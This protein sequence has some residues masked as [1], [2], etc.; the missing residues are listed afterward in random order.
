VYPQGAQS[1]YRVDYLESP[2]R[3]RS[4]ALV[5]AVVLVALAIVGA[6]AGLVARGGKSASP[7][8]TNPAAAVSSSA[9]AP[10]PRQ[11]SPSQGPSVG[12]AQPPTSGPSP[13][14]GRGPLDSYLLPPDLIGSG[15]VMALI[16]GGRSVTDQA[17]LDFCNVDYAS[18]KLRDARVQVQYA[19]DGRAASN[20]FVRYR[21]GGAELAFAEIQ[22]AIAS[23]ASSYRQSGA[24]ISDIHRL[25]GLTGLAKNNAAVSF[26]STYT[27]IGGVVHQATTVI[28]QFDGDYFSGVYVYGADAA[29][30]QGAAGKLG[31]ASAR[32][33]A[34]AASGEPGTGGGP[35]TD[36]GENAPGVQT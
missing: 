2:A 27:G 14:Q 8:P 25:T 1:P 30:V 19:A 11:T 12:G 31:I 22:K 35:M 15:A 10:E 3:R 4:P 28:Y 26:T 7:P 16:P 33:L 29:S 21:P 18:E 34:E 20:E 23:C 9:G 32:L 17:T 6:A 13:S 5:V 36:P 24:E